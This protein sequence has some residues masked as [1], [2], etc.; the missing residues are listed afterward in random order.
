MLLYYITQSHCRCE[1]V[2]SDTVSYMNESAREKRAIPL[3]W[4]REIRN[5][6]EPH[7]CGIVQFRLCAAKDMYSTSVR[8]TLQ[9]CIKYSKVRKAHLSLQKCRIDPVTPTRCRKK[10]KLCGIHQVQYCRIEKNSRS[11]F[12][13]ITPTR[14]RKWLCPR[15][16]TRV[17][18]KRHLHI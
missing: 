13:L 5:F 16:Q 7:R 11:A 12:F 2:L 15:A 18:V 10:K 3:R 17:Y 4:R 1:W 8:Q 14:C 9:F 6:S